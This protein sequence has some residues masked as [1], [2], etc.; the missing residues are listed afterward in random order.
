M[1]GKLTKPV[2]RA[3]PPPPPP[4]RTIT[5]TRIINDS[6]VTNRGTPQPNTTS[7]L[8]PTRTRSTQQ[9][10]PEVPL[11]PRPPTPTKPQP[12]PS[13]SHYAEDRKST[14]LNSSHEWIS[15][16]PSSA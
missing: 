4:P 10:P 16:M 3:S 11:P 8:A 14:R 5:R 9:L 15:R 7:Q 13:G 2:L 1:S 12:K 6:I